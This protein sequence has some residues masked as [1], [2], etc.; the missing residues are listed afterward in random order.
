MKVSEELKP[1]ALAEDGA[2]EGPGCPAVQGSV[3]ESGWV[4]GPGHGSVMM[5]HAEPF[6]FETLCRYDFDISKDERRG[7]L[8]L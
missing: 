2:V 6:D 5:S 3:R 8:P 4:C 7:E 1:E